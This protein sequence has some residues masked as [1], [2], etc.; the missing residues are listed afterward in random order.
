MHRD[1]LIP[2]PLTSGSG[3][4]GSR[5]GWTI[6]NGKVRIYF[7]ADT[8][9]EEWTRERLSSA[10]TKRLVAHRED[11]DPLSRPLFLPL[12]LLAS[13]ARLMFLI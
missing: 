9:S 3:N 5:G 7:G 10:S 1:H 4:G 8:S 6:L 11:R 12:P 2:W 13:S